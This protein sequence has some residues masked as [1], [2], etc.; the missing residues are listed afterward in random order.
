VRLADQA[1]TQVTPNM[2]IDSD[3]IYLRPL[4]DKDCTERYLSWLNDTEVSRF[5]ETRHVVQSLSTIREFVAAVNA[6]RNEHLLGIFL[7]AGQQHVGNIKVGPI[8][9][10]HQCGDVSLLIG[11]KA[12]HGKGYATEAIK[13]VSRYAF[14]YFGAKKLSAGM[15][16]ANQGS[17]KAF[18]KAGYKD[19]GRRRAHYMLDGRRCDLL[20]V[21]LCPADM[22]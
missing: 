5:L 1:R 11:E 12:L 8:H 6:R 9:P 21:G 15:Y 13:I 14:D 18:L 20:L 4:D 2:R 22:V 7:K 19:E 16:E 17:Y 10:Y 3:R